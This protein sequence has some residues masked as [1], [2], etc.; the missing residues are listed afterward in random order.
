MTFLSTRQIRYFN[1]LQY[2]AVN[3]LTLDQALSPNLELFAALCQVLG[4]KTSRYNAINSATLD[5]ALSPNLE[6][7]A[8]LCQVLGNKTSRYNAVNSLTLDQA[9]SPNLELFAASCQML[10]KNQILW[11]LL[12]LLHAALPG[13][14]PQWP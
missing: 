14:H 13:S 4:N 6:L 10:G 11:M 1:P 3:S 12:L 7:F 5:H 8:A 2:N 9:L